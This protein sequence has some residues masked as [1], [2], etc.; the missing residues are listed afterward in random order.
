MSFSTLATA[1]QRFAKSM[2]WLLRLTASIGFGP[3]VAVW[4]LASGARV[5]TTPAKLRPSGNAM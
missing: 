2:A 1:V 3:G 5:W 4:S